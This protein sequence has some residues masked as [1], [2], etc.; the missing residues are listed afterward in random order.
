MRLLLDE[1]PWYQLTTHFFRGL[2]DFGVLSDGGADALRRVLIGI[3]AATLSF[4]LL[5]TRVY[6]ARYTALSQTFHDFGAGYKST[7]VPYHLAVLGDS[8]LVIAFPMLMVGF[9]VVLV[10]HSLFPDE[11]D[12][13]VLLPLPVSRRIVFATK[14]LAV[15]LFAGIF[16]ITAHV[17]MMPLVVLMWN[18]QWTK[19]GLLDQLVAHAVASVGASIVTALVTVA[20]AG[21][22]LVCVPRARVQA[23]A[24]AFRGAALCGLVLSIP[25]ALRLPATGGLI[26]NESPL[27]YGVPPVWFLGVEQLLLGNATP[28]FLRLAQIAAA[29]AITSAAIALG[30]YVFLYQRFERVIFRPVTGSHRFG[31]QRIP[32]LPRRRNS[33]AIAPFICA[34]LTRSPLHQGV[35]VAISACGAG[36]VLHRLVGSWLPGAFSNADESLT[37]AVIWAPFALVFTMDVALRAALVLPIE[38]RAN[39]IFRLTEDQATRAEELNIVVRAAILL[40]VV[41][42]VAVLFPVEWA[43]LGPQAI[44]CTSM[45]FLCGLVLVELHMAEWRRIPFTCSYA[46]TT[47][48]AGLTLLMGVTAFVVFTM[49]GSRLVRY[50]VNHRVGWLAAM[51]I[52]GAVV[53][54]LRRQRLW[55]SEGATLMFEDLLPNEVEPLHLSEY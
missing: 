2:F 53:V 52:L 45:A 50:S 14:A 10:S 18:N 55:L 13:R 1:R 5:L 24:I 4:G 46:P 29:V 32:F 23:A 49:I 47:Q 42:P 37:A 15:M 54:Y 17:A 16:G 35:F 43:V 41:L 40:G 22:I 34:T 33:A 31:R 25:L 3:V 39:W 19:E 48:F 30:S 21:A 28:Y 20:I 9:V 36:L 27:F 12:C 11:I 26:A 38:V 51:T 6:L 8:A 7:R 44:H